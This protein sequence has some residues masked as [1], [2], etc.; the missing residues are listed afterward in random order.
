MYTCAASMAVWGMGQFIQIY[1]IFK[2][3]VQ[4]LLHSSIN[5]ELLWQ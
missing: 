1:E 5:I 3:S 4:I 2:V